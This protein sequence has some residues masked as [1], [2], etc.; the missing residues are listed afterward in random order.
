MT[1][2]DL[3]FNGPLFFHYSAVQAI[4]A[5]QFHIWFADVWISC[6][7]AAAFGLDSRWLEALGRG[8][9]EAM[10]GDPKGREDTLQ[11]LV[12]RLVRQA[13][14]GAHKEAADFFLRLV[15]DMHRRAAK[16]RSFRLLDADRA[17]AFGAAVATIRLARRHAQAAG[18]CCDHAAPDPQA[19]AEIVARHVLRGEGIS[20]TDVLLAIHEF[21]AAIPLAEWVQDAPTKH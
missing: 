2:N 19:V 1:A 4:E 16:G 9:E 13:R 14:R 7:L 8:I 12:K 3:K 15:D 11:A 6:G 10:T 18:A 17:R 5:G 20:V 21:T